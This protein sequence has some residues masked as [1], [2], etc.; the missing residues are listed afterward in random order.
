M[1]PEVSAL[2]MARATRPIVTSVFSVTGGP[3]TFEMPVKHLHTFGGCEGVLK[4]YPDRV[5]YESATQPADSRYWRYGDIQNFGHPTRYR[6]EITTYEDKLGGPTRVF[7]FELKE[8][9]PAQAYDYLWLRLNP[10][11]YYPYDKRVPPPETPPR[12]DRA[13]SRQ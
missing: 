9:F 12:T 6:F 4:I 10:S 2:L 13:V 1:T 8:D 11:E 7:N 3:P 5:N